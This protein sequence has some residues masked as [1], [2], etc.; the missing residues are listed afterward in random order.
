MTRLGKILEMHRSPISDGM[1]SF[2][3]SSRP[4]FFEHV[5]SFQRHRRYQ[6]GHD[7]HD[8]LIVTGL[9]NVADGVLQA[10]RSVNAVEVCRWAVAW[11]RDV[12][13]PTNT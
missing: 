3:V 13:P 8:V 2:V 7:A 12:S 5:A 1:T 9:V 6:S 4:V 11:E 10:D